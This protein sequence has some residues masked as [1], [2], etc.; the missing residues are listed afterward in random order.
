MKRS[1]YSD[2][3]IINILK[4]TDGLPPERGK[5]TVFM[6]QSTE[7]MQAQCDFAWV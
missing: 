7:T 3:Q 2:S 6:K 5:S 1:R 4:Q